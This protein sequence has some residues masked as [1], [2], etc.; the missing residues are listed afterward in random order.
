MAV[1]RQK[2]KDCWMR[3]VEDDVEETEGDWRIQTP[4]RL[5]LLG[6]SGSGKSSLI[7]KMIEDD[8]IFDRP[9]RHVAY[10]APALE[11]RRNYVEELQNVVDRV[12]K[13][14]AI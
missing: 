1:D 11:D 5:E 8:S 3:G 14:F 4:C 12:G 10:C 2:K 13:K 9:C 6:P 7:L